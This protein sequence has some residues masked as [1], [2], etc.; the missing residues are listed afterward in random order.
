MFDPTDPSDLTPEQRLD[1][2]TALLATGLRR[3]LALRPPPLQESAQNPLDV[4]PKS[5]PH[6][7][8]TVN[9]SREQRR[10]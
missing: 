9:A 10:S 7:T 6:G 2:L 5:R 3:V 1:E 8:R 4:C